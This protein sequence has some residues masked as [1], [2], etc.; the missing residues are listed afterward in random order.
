MDGLLR[1]RWIRPTLS[2][3]EASARRTAIH[4]TLC[5]SV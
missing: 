4:V 1:I 2:R 3:S 5:V